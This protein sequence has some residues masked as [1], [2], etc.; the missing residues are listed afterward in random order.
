M[1][2]KSVSLRK[3]KLVI[4]GATLETKRIHFFSDELINLIE[5]ACANQS[6]FLHFQMTKHIQEIHFWFS[7]LAFV[8]M[9]HK[10]DVLENGLGR[11]IH[12][13]SEGLKN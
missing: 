5:A 10:K 12:I 6:A 4:I 8:V 9:I 7:L 1:E 3:R 2:S 11:F 13:T